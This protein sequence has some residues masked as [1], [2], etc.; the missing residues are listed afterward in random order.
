[1]LGIELT[2]CWDKIRRAGEHINFLKAE[3]TAWKDSDPYSAVKKHNANGS[4]HSIVVHLKHKAP[5]ERWSLIAGDVIHNLRSALDH[6]IYAVAAHESKQPI[7]PQWKKIQFPIV[8]DPAKYPE[9][10]T[11][12]KIDTLSNPVQEA[13]ERVQPYNRPHGEV[14]PLLG[15]L[16]DFD[17]TD[18]HRLLNVVMSNISEGKFRVL[19]PTSS[20]ITF[21]PHHTGSIEDGT[22]IIWFTANPPDPNL[23]YYNEAMIVVSVIHEIG[24]NGRNYTELAAILDWLHGEVVFVVNKVGGAVV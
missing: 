10:R 15:L 8:S 24:R 6:L 2:S 18:K 3:L 7:P 5:I 23:D 14:P 13:V 17:D 12:C 22:E 20:K 1:M 4:R 19:H 11:R 9:N 16:A 21:G